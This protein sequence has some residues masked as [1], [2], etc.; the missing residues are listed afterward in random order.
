M[1]TV[2]TQIQREVEGAAIGTT[3]VEMEDGAE[4]ILQI[5]NR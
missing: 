4:E 2:I 3:E 5:P 1:V